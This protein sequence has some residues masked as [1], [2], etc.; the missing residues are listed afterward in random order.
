MPTRSYGNKSTQLTF[1]LCD[2]LLLAIFILPGPGGARLLLR[3]WSELVRVSDLVTFA[4]LV[5]LGHA[6]LRASGLYRLTLTRLRVIPLAQC[7]ICVS[8]TLLAMHMIAALFLQP[9][10]FE[11]RGLRNSGIAIGAILGLRII[12]SLLLKVIR[13]DGANVRNILIVGT[14]QR[15][16]AYAQ[17]LRHRSEL[18]VNIVGFADQKWAGYS[19]VEAAGFR[20]AC[21]LDSLPEFVR[22]HVVDEVTICLPLQSQYARALD[23]A[24]KCGEQGIVANI[25]SDVFDLGTRVATRMFFDRAQVLT[26]APGPRLH[27]VHASGKRVFDFVCSLLLLAAF[28]PVLIVVA[29]IVRLT[30][31]GPVLFKQRRLGLNKRSFEVLKF[32]SMYADAEL[33]QKEIEHLNETAGAA[34]K[35]RNDP[36]ITPVG[37]ILRKL[38][39]DELPQL[40]NVLKGEMSLVGP[41]PLPLRDYAN[42]SEDW[43]RRRL[44]VRPGISG[45][46]QVSGRSNI[47]FQKWMELDLKYIDQ[48][49]FWLDLNIL[50]K[51]IPAVLSG[52]GAY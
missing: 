46:W 5:L 20:I 14:N 6:I 3:P 41:R 16:L 28:S 30:S 7:A 27:D 10:G 48:W 51:T 40:I 37:K 35:L 25:L 45:L 32:R 34:F 29:L 26:V 36:R 24:A 47:A 1:K 31:P 4:S 50:A 15:A 9:H 8:L 11:M 38:S 52:Q 22:K 18:G 33:R 17:S 12:S 42:F 43:H 44:S 49:S 39:I 21:D 13:R 19:I 23:I 2:L